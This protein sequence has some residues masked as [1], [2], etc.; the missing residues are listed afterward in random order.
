[1]ILLVIIILV[2]AAVTGSLGAIL[3]IAAGVAVGLLL[4]VLGV[5]VAIY[6]FGRHKYR[7]AMRDRDRFSA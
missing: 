4:F 5:G 7:Q 3:E 1:M 6:Y 2:A